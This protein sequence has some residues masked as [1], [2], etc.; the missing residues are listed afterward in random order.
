[1]LI[2]YTLAYCSFLTF[3]MAMKKHF[4]QM[5]PQ[6]N[7]LS[8]HSY[9]LQLC[10]WAQLVVALLYCSTQYGAATAVVILLGLL[11]TAA[12]LL[13]LLLNYCPTLALPSAL[14]LTAVTACIT[15]AT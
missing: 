15:A 10:G 7:L 12:I 8:L 6:K 14:L 11:N 3:S 4:Q 2:T 1:M 9:L 5:F 13:A